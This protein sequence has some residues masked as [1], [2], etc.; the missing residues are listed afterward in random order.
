MKALTLIAGSSLIAV[1][2]A[3]ASGDVIDCGTNGSGTPIPQNTVS[4][5]AFGGSPAAVEQG[6]VEAVTGDECDECPED[7]EEIMWGGCTPGWASG[8]TAPTFD[9]GPLPTTPTTYYGTINT[10]SEGVRVSVTCG[11]P[12][13][14]INGQQP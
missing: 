7:T 11:E 14:L 13:Y 6:T 1:T 2:A 10:G 9:I 3:L 4:S 5:G 12:C 8:P